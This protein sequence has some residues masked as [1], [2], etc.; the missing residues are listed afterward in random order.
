MALTAFAI[1]SAAMGQMTN[2]HVGDQAP[3]L[4]VAKWVK[5]QETKVEEGTVYIVE[6]WATWCAPCRKT[7]P[8]LTELQKEYEGQGLRVIGV[9]TEDEKTVA[10]FVRAQGSK[11]DYTVV[12]DKFNA[13]ERAW[14]NS[15][16]QK[17]IPTAFI[18]D[19]KGKVQFIGS[20]F[21]EHFDTV[22]SL[23][24]RGRYDAKLMVQAVP[25][26]KAAE[27]ARK[28]K[29]WQLATKHMQDIYALDKHVFAELLLEQFEMILVDQKDPKGAYAF[30]EAM[31]ITER[32]PADPELMGWLAEKIVTD[33]KI[34]TE[35]RNFEVAMKAAE[36]SMQYARQDDPAPRSVMATVLFHKGE[37]DKAV[38]LQT[39]AWMMAAPKQK[40]D[41]KRVLESYQKAAAR[42]AAR[43]STGN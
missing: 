42:S 32:G 31:M 20:P 4:D 25:H 43:A 2:L 7:I 16:G 9:S 10:N 27:T 35:N 40:A 13:T 8:H 5:G 38:A 18:V 34:A 15:A 39:E 33:P 41:Y 12:V 6:F 23:V 29:N 24:V 22:V 11:M 17:G 37:T 36:T 28:V 1:A 26:L 14:M 3:G 21:D 30:A 19:R